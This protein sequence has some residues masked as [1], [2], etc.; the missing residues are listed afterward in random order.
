[1]R[2]TITFT[3]HVVWLTLT[4]FVDFI[5]LK[6]TP[7]THFLSICA[8]PYAHVMKKPIALHKLFEH[9]VLRKCNWLP[10]QACIKSDNIVRGFKKIK[11]NSYKISTFMAFVK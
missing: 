3:I 10:E 7:R 8:R 4:I 1:M 5:E 11:W 9:I 2:F 6:N